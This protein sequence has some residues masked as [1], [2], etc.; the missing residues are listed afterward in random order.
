[1]VKVAAIVGFILAGAALVF[2]VGS[3]EAIGFSNLTA[4]GGLLP[5]GATVV[6]LALTLVITSYL[7]METVAV[8]AGE[9]ERPEKTVPRALLGAA[10]GPTRPS[11][12][13]IRVVVA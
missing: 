5:N 1:M 13:L 8:T 4:H 12:P 3:R 11:L 9:A 7:G 6:W 2:G 10:A